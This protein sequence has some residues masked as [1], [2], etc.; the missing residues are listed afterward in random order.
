VT[1]PYLMVESTRAGLRGGRRMSAA[2]LR[3]VALETDGIARQMRAAGANLEWLAAAANCG[4]VQGEAAVLAMMNLLARVLQRHE[5]LLD[6]LDA[7]GQTE[8]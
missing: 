6:V 4:V 2:E 7:D 5:R 8:P 3:W 1:V